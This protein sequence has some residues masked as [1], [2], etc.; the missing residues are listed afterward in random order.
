MEYYHDDIADTLLSFVVDSPG[1]ELSAYS[2]YPLPYTANASFVQSDTMWVVD[3]VRYDA[4]T[5]ATADGN[6]RLVHEIAYVRNGPTTE[7]FEIQ[8]GMIEKAWPVRSYDEQGERM[9]GTQT[10]RFA[11]GS[12][13]L[14]VNTLG[15]FAFNDEA[16]GVKERVYFQD[17]C[18]S[19]DTYSDI[20]YRITDTDGYLG[21]VSVS[22][23]TT[24]T[25]VLTTSRYGYEP[26]AWGT[27]VER[28]SV[29]A[30]HQAVMQGTSF[31]EHET[32][33]LTIAGNP[34]R[35]TLPYVAARPC[36]TGGYQQL[37]Q[38]VKDGNLYSLGTQSINSLQETI[39]S[40]PRAEAVI[41]QFM[42]GFTYAPASE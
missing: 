24:D 42:A 9:L 17:A 37:Y 34:V 23:P 2:S 1:G 35:H 15:N 21:Y 39:A 36:E 28:R 26:S 20:G 38:W 22:F 5:V 6:R 18:E 33:L 8:D 12:L 27:V 29:A 32:E 19:P 31:N 4:L 10:Y 3:E 16:N 40:Q 41:A 13:S 25:Y 7:W 11:P 14:M 30:E